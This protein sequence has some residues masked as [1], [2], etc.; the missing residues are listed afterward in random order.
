MVLHFTVG[1]DISLNNSGRR[2]DGLDELWSQK[3][4]QA[5]GAILTTGLLVVVFVLLDESRI[6]HGCAAAP[7]R[8]EDVTITDEA[9]LIIWDSVNRTEHFI[10][11]A[12]FQTEAEDF[13]FLVPTPSVP[14]LHE[15]G[16]RILS[17]LAQRTV[18][19]TEYR[20]VTTEKFRLFK[21]GTGFDFFWNFLPGSA[22]TDSAPLRAESAVEVINE[23]SVAGYDAT[24]L[25][26]TDAAE[27]LKWLEE[28][29]YAAR[30]ALLEWLAAYTQDGWYITAFRISKSESPG[31]SGMMAR[32]V[33]MTF[34][35]ARPFYPYRE[36]ADTR[37]QPA[38][39]VQPRLLRLYVLADQK[40]E[41]HLGGTDTVPATTVWAN[42]LPE[43]E[44]G[45][46][47][48]QF[49]DE[50]GTAANVINSS[51][52]YLT[53]FEDHSSPRPG[54]DELFL[55]PAT[56]QTTVGRPPIIRPVERFVYSPNFYKA[57]FWMLGFGIV[58]GVVRLRLRMTRT[59]PKK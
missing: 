13:G 37:S 21:P 24:I 53:E 50:N 14:T 55:L 1:A 46:L 23:V 36:P 47:N 20:D 32:P 27:L 5:I 26:A 7:P 29:D 3:M 4:K 18:A 40:M 6:S 45:N 2:C 28:H 22:P 10:R 56:D 16:G 51:T 59:L 30:P 44:I 19:R 12:N 33:R 43:F 15:S 25:K 42:R 35:T 17:E 48:R 38:S 39:T 49:P 54:T 52:L 8:D 34:E 31:S 11:N 58:I 57:P 9:A 41:G